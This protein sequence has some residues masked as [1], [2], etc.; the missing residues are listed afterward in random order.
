MTNESNPIGD[1]STSNSIDK[2]QSQSSQNENIPQKGPLSF[3]SGSLTGIVLCL[4]CYRLS[5]YIVIYFST[6]S[7]NYSSPIAQSIASGFKTLIVGTSFLATFTFGFIG[8]GLALVFVRSLFDA[9]NQKS[10]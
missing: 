9:N 7:T 4:V 1:I 6:H 3:L 10:E 8:L 5:Q 2:L